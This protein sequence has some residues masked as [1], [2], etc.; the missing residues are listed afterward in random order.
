M[1][2]SEYDTSG[3]GLDHSIDDLNAVSTLLDACEKDPKVYEAV[4]VELGSLYGHE[5]TL[6]QFPTIRNAMRQG[7]GSPM[8]M[9]ALENFG[10]L[11]PDP[12]L[13]VP[14]LLAHVSDDAKWIAGLIITSRLTYGDQ[15]NFAWGRPDITKAIG[16]ERVTNAIKELKVVIRGGLS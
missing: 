4:L 1:T 8:D 12:E 13:D 16:K 9:E 6:T 10:Q 15:K 11:L 2:D 3:R 7:Q 5:F 14:R